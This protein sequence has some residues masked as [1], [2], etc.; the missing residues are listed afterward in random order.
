MRGSREHCSSWTCCSLHAQSTSAMSSEFPLSQGNAKALDRRGE[1]A[2][3]H[4]ISYFFS[5]TS[6]KVPNIIIIGSCMSRL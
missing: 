4:L 2:K 3:H 5:N 1:K 6:A